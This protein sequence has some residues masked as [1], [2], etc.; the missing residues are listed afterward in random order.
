MSEK[1]CHYESGVLIRCPLNKVKTIK[2]QFCQHCGGDLRKKNEIVPGIFGKFTDSD[3]PDH[4]RYDYLREISG[5]EIFK[6]IDMNGE[7]WENFK[8]G[9]PVDK[10]EIPEPD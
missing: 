8:V 2:N 5:E 10:I 1:L 7:Y 3:K 9:I 4:Y 6:Y